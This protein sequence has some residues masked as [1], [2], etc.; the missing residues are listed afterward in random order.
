MSN[1]ALIV[2][3]VAA[4]IL[5]FVVMILSAVSAA[6]ISKKNTQTAYRYSTWSVLSAGLAIL[7]MV[8]ALVLVV[9]MHQALELAH[10]ALGKY[11]GKAPSAADVAAVAHLD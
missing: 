3:I 1:A 5:L 4:I 8:V 2:T 10:V 11:L 9:Y 6:E 7:L